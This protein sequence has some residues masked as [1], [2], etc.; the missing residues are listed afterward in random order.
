VVIFA[1]GFGPTSTP[2]ISGAITQSG[3]LLPMPVIQV[4]G[5]TATVPF[6]GLILPGEFQFNVI[7]PT[8]VPA[9]DQTITA[10]YNGSTTQAGSIITIQ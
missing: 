8:N 5:I 1:N 3:S 9:G 7:I 6:A 10:T 4:G 2:V